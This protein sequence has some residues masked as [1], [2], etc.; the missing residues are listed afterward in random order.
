MSLERIQNLRNALQ[1]IVD[2]ASVSEGRASKFYS[3]LAQKALD[4]DDN[5]NED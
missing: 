1:E 3:M 4:S 2:I 5:M